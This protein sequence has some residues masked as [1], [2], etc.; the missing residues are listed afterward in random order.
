MSSVSRVAK[1]WHQQRH[2]ATHAALLEAAM[3]L[4]HQR[5]YAATTAGEIA[6][7][8]GQTKGAFYWHFPSKE[9]CFLDVITYREQ[10]R[11]EW[12]RIA[13]DVDPATTTLHD[14]L[15]AVMAGF[16][17]TLRGLNAW[18]LVMV[19]YWFHATDRDEA[20]A[21]FAAIYRGWIDEVTALV[22]ALKTSGW[23]TTTQ[24]SRQIATQLF[25]LAEGLTVHA[26]L[27]GAD[28]D[29]ALIDGFVKLLA[30]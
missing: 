1:T 21:R 25:A 3:R 22:D 17:E 8:T 6:A 4:F 13:A 12:Y 9:A 2:D 20:M 24:D 16:A 14:L 7:A 26:T 29:D 10:L 23:T 18:V 28:A 11:G 15:R 30:S 27:Y 19:D 5:G